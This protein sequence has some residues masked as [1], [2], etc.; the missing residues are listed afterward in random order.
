MLK[1][2]L[3]LAIA[4]ALCPAGAFAAMP[5]VTDDT[6]TQGKGHFQVEFGFESARDKETVE[7]VAVRET[8]RALSAAL[9]YGLSDTVDLVAG[10]PWMWAKTREDGSTVFDDN[11]IGDLALQLKW[12]F[13]ELEDGRLSLALKPGV[14]LPTGDENKGFG[15]GRVSGN[16]TLVATHTAELGALH[17]N[18]GYTR[19]SYR[20]EVDRLASRKHLW[21]ASLAGEL[22]VTER[23]RTV[24]D[25]GVETCSDR[26]SDTHPAYL[27]GG[28]IYGVS[29]NLDLDLGIR[30]GLNDTETDT[31]LLAG[32]TMR[33]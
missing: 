14:T 17:L 24:A 16:V 3:P 31:T 26:E 13:Y 11:G 22:N 8:G 9:T 25:I 30:G 33:F 10:T 29:D 6:G 18:V 32:V 1:K 28:L 4:A 7:G 19:N 12:R 5:L 21:H 2:F 23:L 15:N 20:L 27:L